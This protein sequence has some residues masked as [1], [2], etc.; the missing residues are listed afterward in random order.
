[1]AQ[2]YEWLMKLNDISH[3]PAVLVLV[4]AVFCKLH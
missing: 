2:I 3:H 1:M 4:D